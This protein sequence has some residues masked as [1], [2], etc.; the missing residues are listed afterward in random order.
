MPALPA[1]FDQNVAYLYLGRLSSDPIFPYLLSEAASSR[2]LRL[3]LQPTRL[4]Q[5]TFSSEVSFPAKHEKIF[6]SPSLLFR[7][8][9]AICHCKWRDCNQGR[10]LR[11]LNRTTGRRCE[12]PRPFHKAQKVMI[13]SRHKRMEGIHNERQNAL[14]K[15]KSRVR[16]RHCWILGAS[17]QQSHFS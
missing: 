8:N 6:S 13:K 5:S 17:G 9:R 16:W 15:T 3:L 14:Y 10:G 4:K 1:P 11:G 12:F 2:E 7:S